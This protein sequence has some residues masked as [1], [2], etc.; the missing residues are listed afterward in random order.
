MC[1]PPRLEGLDLPR[2][3]AI[4]ESAI[5]RLRSLPRA[6]RSRSRSGRPTTACRRSRLT[7]TTRSRRCNATNAG[8]WSRIR[9]RATG[10]APRY[11]ARSSRPALAVS[12]WHTEVTLDLSDP[13]RTASLRLRHRPVG[14]GPKRPPS[15]R[16]L[17]AFDMASTVPVRT[18]D[19]G[20]GMRSVQSGPAAHESSQVGSTSAAAPRRSSLRL[21][22]ARAFVSLPIPQLGG[23]GRHTDSR[24]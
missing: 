21:K 18:A 13:A 9:P 1:H 6:Q 3:I 20:R 10:T 2:A 22:H 12:Q 8:C 4:P 15:I 16:H 23:R 11:W 14:R 24:Q 17:T 7:R 5:S 19:E